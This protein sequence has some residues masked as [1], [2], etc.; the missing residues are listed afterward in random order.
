MSFKCGITIATHNRRKDL[1]R[2]CIVISKLNPPPD[3]VLLCA[4]GCTDDTVEYI[5]RSFPNFLLLIHQKAQ[6]SIASRDEMMRAASSDV[7]L[8]LDDDSYPIEL[9]AITRIKGIFMENARLAV[10]TFP[11]R[12]DEYPQTLSQN[13]FGPMQFVGTF[14][15]AGTAIRRDSFILLGGYPSEFHHMY[16][17]PD[18]ALRC[19]AAG[20]EVTLDPRVT[21][22]HHYTG[23]QRNEL[24]IHQLHA[25]NEIWSALMH[26]PFP[27]LPGVLIFR[28]VRQLAYANSRG[29]RWLVSEPQW[30]LNCFRA[31]GRVMKKRRP[32][33][34]ST[35]KAWM[36]LVRKPIFSQTE[37]RASFGNSQIPA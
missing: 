5:R 21:I 4:D 19:V 22:R 11:Q 14:S 15:N 29:I 3:E 27:E 18:F 35:Y 37:W 26:C 23:A 31:L 24:R 12:T 32:I 13:D 7:L 17:E 34:W 20:L 36:N 33:K 9:D 6:G 1:E 30:W 25:R 2:T 28:V 16:E 8:S 10:V